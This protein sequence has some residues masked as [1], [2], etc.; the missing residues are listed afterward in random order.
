MKKLIA[1]LVLL[2]AITTSQAGQPGQW[3]KKLEEQFKPLFGKT[4]EQVIEVVGIP[5]S[6]GRI[7]EELTY[8]AIHP[9]SII[10]ARRAGTITFLFKNDKLIRW[11]YKAGKQP[12]VYTWQLN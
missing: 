7:N 12:V 5:E 9:K 4:T 1:T 3:K 10:Y 6:A 2:F 11:E 8:I